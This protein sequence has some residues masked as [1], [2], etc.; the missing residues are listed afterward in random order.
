MKAPMFERVVLPFGDICPNLGPRKF[1]WRMVQRG[2]L[3]HFCSKVFNDPTVQIFVL[4]PVL[5]LRIACC[6]A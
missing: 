4:P 1:Q 3:L 2:I 5:Y 6:Y